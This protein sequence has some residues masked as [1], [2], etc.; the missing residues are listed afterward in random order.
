MWV[1]FGCS[2]ILSR[3]FAHTCKATKV[4]STYVYRRLGG[5]KSLVA[6]RRGGPTLLERSPSRS[7]SFPLLTCCSAVVGCRDRPIRKPRRP[8]FILVD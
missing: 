4:H 3:V 7:A 2:S 8:T 5:G 6:V 1:R